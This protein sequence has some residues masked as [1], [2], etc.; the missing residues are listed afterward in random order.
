[1]GSPVCVCVHVDIPT[2]YI[3]H[4]C[5]DVGE[6]PCLSASVMQPYVWWGASPYLY[7]ERNLV[8][9]GGVDCVCWIGV[10][11]NVGSL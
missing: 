5:E 7:M 2:V 9:L 1:M 11:F 8:S 3:T 10:L 6:S 4:C